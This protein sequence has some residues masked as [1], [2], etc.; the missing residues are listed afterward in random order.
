MACAVLWASLFL[1]PGA[2]FAASYIVPPGAATVDA[3]ANSGAGDLVHTVRD[4][5]VYSGFMFTNGPMLIQELRYRPSAVYGSAFTS[6]LPNIQINLSTST[7]SAEPPSATFASNRG[8][9][10]TIVLQSN[11]T[12]SSRFTN[13][14]G[15][16]K[17]FDIVFPLTTPFYYDP[18]A[19]HLVVELRHPTA[20]AAT[21][22]D[23]TGAADGGGRV[24]STDPNATTGS[25]DSGCNVL[26]IVYTLPS[27]PPL[28]TGQPQSQ[29]AFIGTTASFGVVVSGSAPLFYQWGFNGAPISAATNATLTLSNLTLVQS[30]DYRVSISNSFGSTNSNMAALMV[31]AAPPSI[32]TQPFG[33]N[34]PS[35]TNFI[36]STAANGALP[37]FYQWTFNGTPIAGATNATLALNNLLTTQAGDY[38]VTVS[39]AFGVT[40]SGVATLNVFEILGIPVVMEPPGPCNR[41]GPLVISEIMYHPA[42]NAAGRKLEFVELFNSGA[43]PQKLDGFRLSGDVDFTFPS[44]TTVAAAG[45]LVV[46]ANLADLQSIYG[47]TNVVGNFTGNLPNDSGTVRLRNKSD[48]VLLEVNYEDSFPWPVAADGSGHSLMLAR[49]SYGEGNPRAWSASG[50]V[51]GTPGGP[52]TAI[53][54]LRTNVLLNEV[55]AHH[56]DLAQNFVELYNHTA[57]NV[58]VGGWWLSDDPATNTWR[59]PDGTVLPARG[60]VSFTQARLGFPLDPTGGRVCL[61]N[62]AKTRV[63]DAVRYGPQ[64]LNVSWGR[65]PD[66]SD[67]FSELALSTPGATNASPLVRPVVISELMYHPVSNLDED[68]YLE[69]FNRATN[70]INM[71]G[72]RLSGDLSYGFP[73]NTLI[74]S[75]GYLVVAKN[76]GRMLT[77][78]P[79][80]SPSLVRGN[81]GGSPS[82]SGGHVLLSMPQTLFT[83]NGAN[84]TSNT[85]YV[86]VNEL[87]YNTGGHWGKWSDG[88]GASLELIDTGSDNRLAANW[89]DSVAAT[90]APWTTITYTGPHEYWDGN[91]AV[92]ALEIS[93]LGEGECAI[94]NADVHAAGGVNLVSNTNFNTASGWTFEGNHDRSFITNS[95]GLNNSACLYLRAASR[96]DY[97]GSRVVTTWTPQ[98][99]T[100]VYGTIS[101]KAR[102]IR[103]WPELLCRL[104]GGSLEATGPLLLPTDPG[105]PGRA[106]S[107]AV[108]N[109]GPAILEV[110]HGPVLPAG[111]EAIVVAA[112]VIDPNG[113]TNVSV[114]YRIDPSATLATLRMNDQGTNGDA[115]AGDGVYSRLDR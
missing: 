76:I 7:G 2:A 12:L 49:P 115:I 90:N 23:V 50:M 66:G 51:G 68:Q 8:V 86:V 94:D 37:L 95:G 83:T 56:A 34:V 57:T 24:F 71:G 32:I 93:M 88:G 9:D 35:G 69:L 79:G 40:N 25:T 17:G 73:P 18:A 1:S 87:T 97:L 75:H 5:T 58:D 59:I 105:T 11:I 41:R 62:P 92:T 54:D 45:Y 84:I 103:G 15:N 43:V 102:W 82:G 112:R 64:A 111:G 10:D 99:N 77:N 61:F 30:G 98:M 16:T 96:G 31:T 20:D 110:A 113:V 19:G 33:G 104:R 60:F 72:W 100:N 67:L 27:S 63:I 47:V 48:A 85:S 38:A 4:Q 107:R 44:N 21:Y 14:P 52:E 22:L 29:N 114:S 3:G 28:I 55:R 13:G 78:Y 101:V 89:A 80:L 26:Q 39:N 91:T 6:S 53:S 46:A 36:F 42:P 65:S 109:A 70:A 108:T 74:D 106:N 81:F